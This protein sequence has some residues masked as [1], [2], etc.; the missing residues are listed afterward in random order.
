MYRLTFL[1]Y[2]HV[3]SGLLLLGYRV[4][5]IL[6]ICISNKWF[7]IFGILCRLTF[8]AYIYVVSGLLLLGYRVDYILMIYVYQISGLSYLGYCV[9]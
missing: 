4:D 1:A 2:I 7:V 5:Y 6:M 8:L 9:D 3:V